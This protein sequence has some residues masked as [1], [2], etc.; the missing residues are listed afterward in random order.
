V[1]WLLASDEP[2]VTYLTRRDVLGE[3]IEPDPK[4]ILAGPMVGTEGPERDDHVERATR[5]QMA[6]TP[7]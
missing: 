4:E 3:D 1:E 2:A 5:V 7:P 6:K